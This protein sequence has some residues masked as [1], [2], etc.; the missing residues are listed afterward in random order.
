MS[1]TDPLSQSVL[2][3]SK[4]YLPL[5]QVNVKRAIV[6]LVSGRAEPVEF[7]SDRGIPI[8]SP[9]TVLFVPRYIRLTVNHM[10]RNWRVPA[11]SRREIL[12]RDRHSCQYCG[13]TKR[14]TLD[15]VVPRS[16]GG[17]HSW[18]NIVTACERC[19]SRKGDRT[20]QQAGMNL[21]S[22]PKP[23]IHPLM[24]FADQFWREHG[25]EFD[26]GGMATVAE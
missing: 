15:H 2:V 7:S 26:Y 18:N 23:P 16:K 24:T 20:P 21:R 6:L 22:V 14:L 5:N 9:S 3:F 10:H 4:S 1:V 19:N 17:P 25:R 8:H 13:S 11:V 12:K